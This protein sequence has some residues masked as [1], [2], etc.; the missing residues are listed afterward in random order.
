VRVIDADGTLLG[1]IP[2]HQAQ[3]KAQDAGLNL[4]EVNAKETPPVC[5]IMDYGKFKYENAKRERET[6]RTRIVQET[7]EVKF[8][9]KTHDHDFDFKV[10]HARRF[11]EDGDKVRLLVQFRGREMVHPETGR[12]VLDRVCKAVADLASVNQMSQ[13]EGNRMFMVL[14][15][16]AAVVAAAQA[17]QKAKDAEADARG[18][19]PEEDVRVDAEEGSESEETAPAKA[20]P[21]AE[22]ADAE[23]A[24][25]GFD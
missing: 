20:V 24:P 21:A 14:A 17:R 7:K 9:P 19:K 18:P 8:R 25:V 16:K 5:K 13:M 3:A 2:T 22:P 4:V 15:P 12:D 23:P 11:L 6:K 10:A 1:V